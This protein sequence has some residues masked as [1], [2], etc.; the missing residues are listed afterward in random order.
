MSV[1]CPNCGSKNETTATPC[2]DCGFKLG[3][4]TA[5]KFKG[6][7]MLSSDQ[8]VKDL[9]AAHN[10]GNHDPEREPPLPASES[11]PPPSVRKGTM[12][13][14]PAIPRPRTDERRKRVA[15]TM[16]GVAPQE[17]GTDP[18]APL[19]APSL[20]SADA[21]IEK[22]RVSPVSVPPV[23]AT[24]SIPVV[25][26]TPAGVD[27]PTIPVVSV[28]PA[29]ADESTIPVSTLTPSSPNDEEAVS[30]ESESAPELAVGEPELD[31]ATGTAIS[32]GADGADAPAQLRSLVS[33]SSSQGHRENSKSM[34]AADLFW[35]IATCGVY[36]V[37][38]LLRRSRH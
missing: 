6:T 19:L 4:V 9:L 34:S 33:D 8:S 12:L 10:E 18:K 37:V 38:R 5:P 13:G 3:G 23:D 14:I 24:A 36:A 21:G 15:G 16:L 20:A 27:E 29:G 31:T 25:S 32:N 35:S 26:V 1:F 28:T 17:G 7:M 30:T 2:D 22:T 11:S